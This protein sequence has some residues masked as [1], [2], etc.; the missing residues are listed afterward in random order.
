M[1]LQAFEIGMIAMVV[2]PLLVWIIHTIMWHRKYRKEY[3]PTLTDKGIVTDMD[4]DAPRYNHV[5]K[6]TD[7]EDFD[8]FAVFEKIGEQEFDDE[9]VYKHFRI[10]DDIVL[11][12]REVFKVEKRN[13]KKR[14]VMHLEFLAVITPK[15][16]KVELV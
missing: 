13:P 12:Y 8:T 16:K 2:V 15:G 1:K 10:D 3:G 4:Y 11:E 5:T 9:D 14:E 6:T 7:S